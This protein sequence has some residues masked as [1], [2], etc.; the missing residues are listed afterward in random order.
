LMSHKNVYEV[1]R[2]E[3]QKVESCSYTMKSVLE[4]ESLKKPFDFEMKS[5][6]K[7][8]GIENPTFV[9]CP[10]CKDDLVCGE[11]YINEPILKR[12]WKE[13]HQIL[14]VGSNGLAHPYMLLI[15]K[16]RVLGRTNPLFIIR[17]MA[18][19]V[20]R[21]KAIIAEDTNKT[22][23]KSQIRIEAMEPYS[24]FITNEEKGPLEEETVDTLRKIVGDQFDDIVNLGTYRNLNGAILRNAQALNPISDVHMMINATPR[25][26]LEDLL[27]SYNCNITTT[28]QFLAD[29]YGQSLCISGTGLFLIA[30]STNHACDPNLVAT[31]ATNNYMV[32]M[33]A[34]KDIKENEE[35]TI[36][37]I[38]K[39]MDYSDRQAKLK[40]M[41]MFDCKCDRCK[42]RW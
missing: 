10:H 4:I 1:K 40:E 37:Y 25:S 33:I 29:Q 13:Y 5:Y 21:A 16:S 35:L 23:T 9:Y 12:A 41:Y 31:S 15:E 6:F 39:E 8:N 38:D 36:S 22:K 28:E 2:D 30:N 24:M 20:Q 32:T 17:M 19:M 18:H 3:F 26:K 42:Y 27:Y 7:K 34:L 14:C 11:K